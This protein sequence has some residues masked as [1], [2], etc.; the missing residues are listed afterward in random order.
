MKTRFSLLALPA[1]LITL[2]LAAC[3]AEQ[4]DSATKSKSVNTEESKTTPDA[5]PSGKTGVA[6]FAGGC[7]WCTEGVFERIPGVT[8]VLSG[9][10]GG[11]DPNP[12]YEKVCSTT[13]KGSPENHTEAIQISYDPG[14]VSYKKLLEWFW[15]AHDPTT[16]NRQGNDAGTQ[17]RSAIFF[18]NDEQKNTALA[19]KKFVDDSGAFD[20]PIVTQIVEVGKFHPAEGYHQDYFANNPGDGY[21]NFILVPKLQKLFKD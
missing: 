5:K 15:K 1:L 13:M 19:S 9:Y 7:F 3:A 2:P 21:C 18:H 8:D 4:E 6:T 17:Y 11:T 20:N 12:T 10:A 16:L 14:I